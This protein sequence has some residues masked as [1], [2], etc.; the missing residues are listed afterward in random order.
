[1]V[2][3][4]RDVQELTIEFGVGEFDVPGG[5]ERTKLRHCSKRKAMERASSRMGLKSGIQ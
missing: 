3:F 2:A 1:L 5:M 4:D